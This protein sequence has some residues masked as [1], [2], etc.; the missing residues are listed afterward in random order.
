MIVAKT[1]SEI[2]EWV[3]QKRASPA[4]TVGFV[5]TMGALHEGHLSLMRQARIE[6]DVVVVS[7]FVN[8]LQ[9]NVQADFDKYPRTDEKDLCQWKVLGDQ[10][11]LLVSLLWS[12]SCFSP[13]N[14]IVPTSGK[15]ITNNSLSSE[16]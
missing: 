10:D 5:P 12:P 13:Y 11:I 15:R 9:F 6:C 1:P 3:K 2:R 8:P 4:V 16:K 7:I 14:P